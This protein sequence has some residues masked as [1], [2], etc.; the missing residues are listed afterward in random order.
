MAWV[1]ITL[2][3]GFATGAVGVINHKVS[4]PVSRLWAR[5]LLWAAGISVEVR[6]VENIEPGHAAIYA[7]NHHSY[8]D[9]VSVIAYFPLDVLFVY[10]RG[11]LALPGLN[12]AMLGQGHVGVPRSKPSKAARILLR[13]GAALLGSGTSIWI[14]PAGG[15][16]RDE[17]AGDFKSGAAALAIRANAP[18]VP[19]GIAGSRESLPFGNWPLKPGKITITIGKP[20]HTAGFTITKKDEL[21]GLVKKQ[22]SSL[23]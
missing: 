18:I 16:S 11:L 12:V 5:L 15:R 22:V 2:V 8:L 23:V 19:V 4:F 1:P 9:V 21:T 3:L 6:G 17:T 14:F 10:K 7:S 20:I 13:R